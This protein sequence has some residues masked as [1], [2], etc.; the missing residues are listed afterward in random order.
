MVAGEYWK[1]PVM[2]LVFRT[3]GCIPVGRRGVDTAATK[4]AIRL[5]NEG[6]LVGLFPEGRINTSSELLLPGRPARC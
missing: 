5:A 4:Q 1:Y 2:A 6:G 3:L